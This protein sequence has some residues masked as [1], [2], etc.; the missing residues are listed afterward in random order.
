MST[1]AG[2]GERVEAVIR[3]GKPIGE[4]P[5]VAQRLVS[6]TGVARPTASSHRSVLDLRRALPFRC[7]E[8]V[9]HGLHLRSRVA[10]PVNKLAG[11]VNRLAGPERM[12]RI[13]SNLLS[14][15]LGSSSN[16]PVGSTI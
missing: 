6:E 13:A 3:Q 1:V 16:A 12:R 14:V 10:D 4:E 2:R 7:L 8:A 9:S 15:T 5:G 11:D